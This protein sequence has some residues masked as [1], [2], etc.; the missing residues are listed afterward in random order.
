MFLYF[1]GS[2][3]T[4]LG[5]AIART[6]IRYSADQWI[7]RHEPDHPVGN[8]IGWLGRH[9]LAIYLV[10][11]PVLLSLILPLTNWLGQP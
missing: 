9:S 7:S 10:H 6:A 3:L 5:L 1:R 11:Q 2:V 8:G 4:L